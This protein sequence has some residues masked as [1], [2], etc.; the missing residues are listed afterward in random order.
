MIWYYSY[1][2][3]A[4]NPAVSL[5]TQTLT[6][7]LSNI[8]HRHCGSLPAGIRADLPPVQNCKDLW[9]MNVPRCISHTSLLP[10]WPLAPWV[11]EQFPCKLPV[12]AMNCSVI[13][14]MLIT[15]ITQSTQTL[16]HTD[17]QA[18]PFGQLGPKPLL[19]PWPTLALSQGRHAASGLQQDEL[20]HT[21]PEP[22][23]KL[24]LHLI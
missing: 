18:E 10:M 12:S 6:S 22:L 24:A 16:Q 11:V 19:P 2:A 4:A 23:W 5:Y 8:C 20:F 7:W 21:P 17:L 15:C 9:N 13:A 1:A 3:H 14:W